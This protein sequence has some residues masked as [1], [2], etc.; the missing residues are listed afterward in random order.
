MEVLKKI[1]FFYLIVFG[2]SIPFTILSII[3]SA[4]SITLIFGFLNITLL[5]LLIRQSHLLNYATLILDNPILT[6]S[7][8][9][10]ISPEGK[11]KI[12]SEETI[13]S[14]FGILIGNKIYKWGAG[15]IHGPRLKEIKINPTHISLAFGDENRS[16][17][18]QLLHEVTN[19]EEIVKVKQK[20]WNEIGV[21]AI[22][23]N[24]D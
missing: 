15:G 1:H 3:K 11:E 13:I 22:I 7:S 4:Y 24:W 12:K 23:S 8:A 20:L 21:E 5:I 14:T 6:V 9:L 19:K 2:I 10:I 18:I 17:K 16:T